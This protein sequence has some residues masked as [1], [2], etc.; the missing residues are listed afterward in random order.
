MINYLLCWHLHWVIYGSLIEPKRDLVD[1]AGAPY[2]APL[3]DPA[4]REEQRKGG[5]RGRTNVSAP[6]L[7]TVLT[8]EFKI[9][10]KKK[11]Q[12]TFG[13]SGEPLGMK[14]GAPHSQPVLLSGTFQRSLSLVLCVWL[15]SLFSACLENQHHRVETLRGPRH[16]PSCFMNLLWDFQEVTELSELQIPSLWRESVRLDDPQSLF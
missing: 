9:C 13:S 12:Q 2:N 15:P 6:W 1:P 5:R 11:K 8:K 3:V 14:N 16:S 10:L 4:Q 7:E